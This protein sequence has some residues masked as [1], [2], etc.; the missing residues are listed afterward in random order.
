MKYVFAPSGFSYYTTA[1]EAYTAVNTITD[2]HKEYFPQLIV[3]VFDV[4]DSV[5]RTLISRMMV[6]NQHTNLYRTVQYDSLTLNDIS[7][8]RATELTS[9]AVLMIKGTA[10][11]TSAL[12]KY[13][14][15]LGNED[16]GG[17][18]GDILAT[19]TPIAQA[20]GL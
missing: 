15:N 11:E 20:I 8:S 19:L 16:K 6:Q 10:G 14:A 7:S 18:F 4:S 5:Q 9:L 12:A 1:S 13:Y 17:F 3:P 2:T